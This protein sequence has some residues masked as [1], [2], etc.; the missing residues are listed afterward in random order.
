MW[1]P[2]LSLNV[3]LKIGRIE[4]LK[5]AGNICKHNVLRSIQ[6]MRAFQK[7][8]ADSGAA[9][10]LNHAL[11]ATGE[12][13]EWLHR[14]KFFA[15][16]NAIV[17]FLND[18]RWGIRDYLAPEYARSKINDPDGVGSE[19]RRTYVAD[20]LQIF[21][22]ANMS[23]PMLSSDART[24]DLQ[25]RGL[26]LSTGPNRPRTASLRLGYHQP[27]DHDH[28][29]KCRHAEAEPDSR[30]LKILL[31]NRHSVSFV[32]TGE[33]AQTDLNSDYGDP[34]DAGE[35]EKTNRPKE[36]S[37][38]QR[39]ADNMRQGYASYR[40]YDDGGESEDPIG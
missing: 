27:K 6:T 13:Y 31:P 26:L 17:Q 25:I 15:Q 1:L 7:A 24:S 10:D 16:S 33:I 38:S 39:I 3:D 21:T 29:G 19:S 11:L 22:F 34:A 8:L 9:V 20:C 14:D 23:P 35:A 12:V 40:L 37:A 2:T 28:R 32:G 5:I 36:P 4:L 18:I 30:I